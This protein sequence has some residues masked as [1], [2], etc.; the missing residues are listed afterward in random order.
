MP[1]EATPSGLPGGGVL[2]WNEGANAKKFR[3]RGSV[4]GGMRCVS[5]ALVVGG[6]RCVSFAF[7]QQ[8]AVLQRHPSRAHPGR[9]LADG[10]SVTGGEPVTD[11]KYSAYEMSPVGERRC[12]RAVG[13]SPLS[14]GERRCGRPV[15]SV[16][17][18]ERG[19]SARW[20]AFPR[21]AWER[22]VRRSASV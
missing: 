11:R 22:L 13:V 2:F 8:P 17:T 3:L 5:F 18:G 10:A 14:G 7:G 21:S 1:D 19:A 6:M 16:G 9:R 20:S 12:G 4:V 15:L